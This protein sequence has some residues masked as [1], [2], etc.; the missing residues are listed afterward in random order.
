[1]RTPLSRMG[2]TAVLESAIGQIDS[3]SQTATD[4]ASGRFHSK[5]AMH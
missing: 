4:S 3:I 5:T 2:R 1:M